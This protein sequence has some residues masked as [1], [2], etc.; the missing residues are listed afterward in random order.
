M[1]K[2]LKSSGQSQPPVGPVIPS[3]SPPTSKGES[4]KV[5]I[6]KGGDFALD[7][8]LDEA[9]PE[10]GVLTNDPRREQVLRLAKRGLKLFPITAHDKV[11]L[12]GFGWKQL[13]TNDEQQL[14]DWFKQYPNCNWAVAMGSESKV[15][16]LDVD[17]E[18]GRNSLDSLADQACVIP[19]TL[20]TE[21]GKP[22]SYHFW[23]E[24]PCDGTVVQNSAGKLAPGLDI[25]GQGGYAVVPPSIHPNGT[26]YTFANE[27]I[28]IAPAPQ[29]LLELV[30]KSAVQE[31]GQSTASPQGE[32]IPIGERHKALCSIAGAM[33]RRGCGE[34]EILAALMVTNTTR[35]KPP[36]SKREVE[37]LARDV[38][39]RYSPVTEQGELPHTPILSNTALYGVAGQVVNTIFPHTEADKPALLLHFLAGYGNL[40]GRSAYC[41]AD[42][43]KHYSNI[44]FV[45]VGATAE[46]KK[47]TSWNRMQEVFERID[48][49]WVKTRVQ[50]G[51]SS[52][53]GLIAAVP[54]VCEPKPDVA[55]TADSISE[56]RLFVVQP[57][58]ASTLKVMTREGNVL[59]GIIR[60]AWDSG[61][62]QIMVKQKPMRVEDAH[63]SIVGHITHEELLR[64]LTLTESANGFANRF[65]WIQSNRSKFLPEGGFLSEAEMDKL[66]ELVRPGVKF[67]GSTGLLKRDEEA[68]KLWADHYRGLS[69]GK[70]GML[71]AIISRAA[72]QVL[73]LSMLYALLDC[74]VEI[75]MPHL[76]AALAVWE[77]C[78]QTAQW[79]FGSR[80]G[81]ST[82]DE[83][84]SMLLTCP[85]GM[86]RNEIMNHFNRHK[87]SAEI[88]RALALLE[89]HGRAHVELCETGGRQ[90]ELWMAVGVRENS[91]RGEESDEHLMLVR[92]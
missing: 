24:Y 1:L 77:Y 22:L 19:T 50:K 6:I 84:L 10:S 86:T 63:I 27:S 48:V 51:L 40:I 2:I 47:G 13:A 30:A 25:R 45:C 3:Q 11:P 91:Q 52:G 83:I 44:F 53:E 68:K 80:V 78:D 85:K 20:I 55:F 56:K 39:R 62:L 29:W 46:G 37:E 88:G 43:A 21:T 42:G 41:I 15:F 8:K 33:R 49:S 12:K 61:F 82:A 92:R 87:S 38:S 16:V 70:P 5:L 60:E 14:C 57:E 7:C 89:K 32:P 66:A 71:G 67:G 35:C 90:A 65:L 26:P 73:R 79:I 34:D 64:Y 23:F 36:K 76:M 75:K 74:S 17:G 54:G 9:P 69:E 72:P 81:D 58:F 18:A 4:G 28:P 59:S 31:S